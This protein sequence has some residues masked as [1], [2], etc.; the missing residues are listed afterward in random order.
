[1]RLSIL[2][3]HHRKLLFPLALPASC[4]CVCVC[5]RSICIPSKNLATFIH[6][7]FARPTTID[8]SHL[9]CSRPPEPHTPCIFGI[10]TFFSLLCRFFYLRSCVNI[11]FSTANITQIDGHIT[12]NNILVSRLFHSDDNE[13]GA[14]A[15][16]RRSIIATKCTP[17][18]VRCS[19]SYDQHH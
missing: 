2:L 7:A 9:S 17:G 16:I 3:S 11:Y 5:C 6:L 1:M 18:T 8:D 4:V 10:H 13:T 15:P 14:I 12:Y 19:I